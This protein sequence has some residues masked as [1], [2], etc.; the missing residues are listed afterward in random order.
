[1]NRTQFYNKFTINGIEELDFLYNSL[2]QF[3]MKY[4]PGYYRVTAADIPDPALISFRVYGTVE[5]WWIV[6]LVNGIQNPLLELE[7][8]I[9]LQI[10]NVIDIYDFQEKYRV[11]E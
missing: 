4:Q 6:L 11:R 9:I 1:M 7:A 10:P 3:K 8:G 5:F 2:S